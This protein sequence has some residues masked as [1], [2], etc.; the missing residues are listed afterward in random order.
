M[1]RRR[2]RA[3][4]FKPTDAAD[5]YGRRTVTVLDPMLEA[6]TADGP[7][8]GLE[9]KLMLYG[10]FVGE[11][12]FD[13]TGY[14]AAGNETLTAPG[15]WCFAWV[16]QGRAVQDVWICPARDLYGSPDCPPQREYG[17][18]V[19]FYDPEA[20]L[21]RIVWCGPGFGN[22]R[23]FLATQRGDE[24]VQEGTTPDGEPLNWI[25]SD[26]TASSFRWRSQ[27]LRG[28]DW[29]LRERMSVRRR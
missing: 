5:V 6:L 3:S 4:T 10:Q 22:L 8:R 29:R 1:R 2:K 25:F 27:V 17:T 13:W 18:T 11:W 19:R 9:D 21:W 14:D 7:A 26:I 24:I 20:D 23:T 12:E 28:D 16:L 15:E